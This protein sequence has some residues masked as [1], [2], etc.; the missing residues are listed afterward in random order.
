M[1]LKEQK[2][3]LSWKTEHHISSSWILILPSH[4]LRWITLKSAG[5]VWFQKKYILCESL[6]KKYLLFY[7]KDNEARLR[8]LA[9]WVRSSIVGALSER[10]WSTLR[11]IFKTLKVLVIKNVVYYISFWGKI[12]SMVFILKSDS[13]TCAF[14]WSLNGKRCKYWITT[15]FQKH[16]ST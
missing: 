6:W 2:R 5:K 13:H 8:K 15:V 12:P 3:E 11:H 4:P 9:A 7:G 10:G 16:A 14:T 1:F